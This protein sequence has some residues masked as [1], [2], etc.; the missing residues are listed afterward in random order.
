MDS[1]V[2]GETLDLF[3]KLSP[4]GRPYLPGGFDFQRRFWFMGIGGV[5][6]TMGRARA[7]AQNET[8]NQDTSLIKLR[9]FRQ[10]IS[11]RIRTAL[12]GV[13]G[14]AAAALITGDRS[15]IPSDALSHMRDAGLAHPLAISGLHL[16]LVATILF[17]VTRAVLACFEPVALRWP[18]KKI[19]ALMALIGAFGYMLMSGG[20]IPTQRAFLMTGLALLAIAMDRSP[21]SLRLVAFGVWRI[22]NFACGA[23]C[24]AW[25]QFPNVLCGRDRSGRRV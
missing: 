19:A 2:V 16:G 20:T 10:S 15:A 8:E 1:P 17:F 4:P 11:D 7:G 21:F 5:G 18:I 23:R 9:R 13:S 14:A 22:F 25:R 6:F 12:P 3:A 24:V